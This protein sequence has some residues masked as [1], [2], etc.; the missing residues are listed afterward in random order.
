VSPRRTSSIRAPGVE[1]AAPCDGGDLPSALGFGIMAGLPGGTRTVVI[2]SV[3]IAAF[4]A[5]AAS[6]LA[7]A[8]VSKTA[9]LPWADPAHQGQLEL[10]AGRIASALA[11]RTVAVRCESP[12][13]W[14]ALATQLGFDVDAEL[15][16]VPVSYDPLGQTVA[17]DSTLIELAPQV[18][19]SLQQFASSD[20]KPTTCTVM[21]AKRQAVQVRRRVLVH[22]RVEVNGRVR[23]QAV[24]R[25]KLVRATVTRVKRSSPRPCFAAGAPVSGMT[26]A[27][28]SRYADDASAILVLAHEAVHLTQYRAGAPVPAPAEAESEAQCVGMQWMPSVA[29]QLGDTSA[30]AEAIAQYTYDDIYPDFKG[31]SYWSEGCVP[32]GRLDR[33][34]GDHRAWP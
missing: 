21:I 15:G 23:V 24:W 13:S 17:D 27:F 31:T 10:L 11:G 33:R 18:C 5:A 9:G 29:V 12:D 4:A 2:V 19:L 20:P 30:D 26:N 22:E 8:P 34:P 6:S 16:Y 32:G 14:Q 25:V 3:V 1:R 7:G 28:W